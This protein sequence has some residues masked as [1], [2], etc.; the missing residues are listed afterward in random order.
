MSF[1]N[2]SVLE[3]I[4]AR[5]AKTL[6]AGIQLNMST[7]ESKK[8]L[9]R[10]VNRK[11]NVVIMFTDVNNSTEM[12]LSLSE[13]RFALMIQTFAQEISI[14]VTGYG[15]YVFK[16]EG[17]AVIGLFPGEYDQA[18]ACK[19]ALNCTTSIL[20]I[21]REVIN[22]AFK[23]NGLPEISVRIGLTYG[24]ALVVLYGNSLEKA[25]ID[26]IGSSISLASKI[27]S[28]AK[29]NQV[30]VGESIYNILLSSEF[31]SD[32]KFIEIN[33]DPTKWKYLS[34]SDPE[35]MYRVYEYHS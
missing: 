20:E 17:D 3:Q 32:G 26:I 14:A 7:D 12:S 30:L 8:L 25:Y 29:P 33:L 5:V 4:R 31:I 24:Y 19:N 11:T 21:I 2:G 15:G 10:H 9:K 22:P 1:T 16:Y 13:D 28:I 35:S 27:V 18:K 23:E 6:T 34:R